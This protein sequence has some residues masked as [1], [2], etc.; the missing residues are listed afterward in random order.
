[1]SDK[2]LTLKKG[3]NAPVAESAVISV[4]ALWT[5]TGRNCAKFDCVGQCIART[6][7]PG[8]FIQPT[9]CYFWR[10]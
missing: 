10:S 5:V 8:R 6:T 3:K 2:K 1:M 9:D 7:F 4:S